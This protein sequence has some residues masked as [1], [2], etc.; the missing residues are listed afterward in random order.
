MPDT[1]YPAPMTGAE[2][3][4]IRKK[5]F[6]SVIGFGR[7]LGYGGSDNTVSTVIRRYESGDR[8]IPIYM[9]RLA[10]MY[11]RH[12]V[13]TEFMTPDLPPKKQMRVTAAAAGSAEQ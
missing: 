13:P 2:F 10:T 4:A 6:L 7:V 11:A 12:G 8:E 1:Q 5:L 9:A 3:R